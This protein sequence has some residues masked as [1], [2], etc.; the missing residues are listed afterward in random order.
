MTTAEM[1]DGYL[2]NETIKQDDLGFVID[3]KQPDGLYFSP[4]LPIAEN[5]HRFLHEFD[6][7]AIINCT[8]LFTE[9]AAR[10]V[11]ALR[12]DSATET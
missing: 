7:V 4:D 8:D 11:E 1:M 3:S 10:Q 5:V 6:E 12:S 9:E 2:K